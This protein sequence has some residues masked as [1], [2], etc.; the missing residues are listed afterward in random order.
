[1][2]VK[3]F[4]TALI[5]TSFSNLYAIEADVWVY[6]V[7]PGHT[8]E[9]VELFEEAIKLSRSAGRNT[10]IAQQTF[11]KGGEFNFHWVDFYD[12]PEERANDNSYDSAEFSDFINRFYKSGAVTTVRSYTMSL[13]DDQLCEFP[14]I[15]SVYVWKPNPG[16]LSSVV[17]E[18]KAGSVLFERHGWEVDLWQENI[19]GRDN[20][21]FVMCSKSR[22]DEAKSN[23][24]LSS[25]QEW[26][27][28]Q[29]N[30][31]LWDSYSDNSKFMGS[32]ELEPIVVD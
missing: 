15:V 5:L 30:A 12:S 27:S 7:Q 32:F 10:S 20:L 8:E 6:K 2:K 29:P 17:E 26:L 23:A 16:E 13:I 19:G 9:A 22:L 18:F 3:I 28:Q 24:S 11:G 1:M 14:G 31:P 4:L 25:D 21:Q